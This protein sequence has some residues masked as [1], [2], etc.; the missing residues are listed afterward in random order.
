MDAQTEAA[1][2]AYHEAAAKFSRAILGWVGRTIRESFPTAT[3]LI[4]RGDME[5]SEFG[6]SLCGQ[7]LLDAEG[8]LVLDIEGGGDPLAPCDVD[9][10]DRSENFVSLIEEIDSQLD[11]LGHLDGED[12]WMGK[13]EI[14]LTPVTPSLTEIEPCDTCNPAFRGVLFAGIGGTVT[15]ERCD[16]CQ[17]YEG[18]LDAGWA[19]V[20]EI[21]GRLCFNQSDG[22]GDEPDG[23]PDWEIREFTGTY[24][25]DDCIAYSTDAWI[26]GGDMSKLD[27]AP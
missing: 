7:R 25:D 4:T 14:D 19:L 3:T 5:G 27:G 12:S 15:V 22:K 9:D 13:Q 16:A 6:F 11:W 8:N 10:E 18:D 21:G 1:Q 24:R 23:E 2:K 26:E 20:Q 17:F